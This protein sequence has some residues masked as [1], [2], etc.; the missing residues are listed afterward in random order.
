M[1]KGI[2]T[3]LILCLGLTL[4]AQPKEVTIVVTGEG[5]T[6]EEATNNALR[7]AVEQTYGVFVSANTEILNDEILKDEIATLSSGNI[8]SFQEIAYV[9]KPSGEKVITLQVVVSIGKLVAYSKSHG[10]EAE[11]AGAT[12]QANFNLFKLNRQ[13][14]QV[15]INNLYRELFQMAPSMYDYKLTVKDPVVLDEKDGEVEMIVEV[16]ANNRT[17]EIG[18]YFIKSLESLSYD[19]KSIRPFSDMGNHFYAY[20]YHS[21]LPNTVTQKIGKLGK[22]GKFLNEFSGSGNSII[23][24]SAKY[25]IVGRSYSVSRVSSELA[26]YV[27]PRPKLIKP[28]YTY[29]PIDA[30]IINSIFLSG[31]YG[32]EI[33]DSQGKVW[34]TCKFPCLI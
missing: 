30:D 6:K 4:V 25:L 16:V 14:S 13:S 34:D 29:V 1:K 17:K 32:F 22:I 27:D 18:D 20:Y 24:S 5:A 7:S 3:L 15:A 12:F 10:S 28:K 31:I 23:S 26:A 33:H 19:E 8:K 9:E 2:I 11:F 21:F